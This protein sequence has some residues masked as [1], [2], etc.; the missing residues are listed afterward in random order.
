[1][2]L[3]GKTCAVAAF[4]SVMS[5][6]ALLLGEHGTTSNGLLVST[7]NPHPSSFVLSFVRS[8]SLDVSWQFMV[9]MII[10]PMNIAFPF[11]I[12]IYSDPEYVAK[13]S[14][15]KRKIGTA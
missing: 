1:M 3:V 2:R 12:R 8:R 15:A 11:S 5:S 10:C 7:S 6:V 4:R 9:E 13:M 14:A